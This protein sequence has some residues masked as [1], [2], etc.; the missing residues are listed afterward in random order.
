MAAFAGSSEPVFRN[1][2]L[3]V[4]RAQRSGLVVADGY[5]LNA[6][7]ECRSYAGPE[8]GLFGLNHLGVPY[9]GCGPTQPSWLKLAGVPQI[10]I[11][12]Q[13]IRVLAQDAQDRFTGQPRCWGQ[14]KLR[15]Q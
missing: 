5:A 8:K 3:D 7:S 15:L 13:S 10:E 1:V 2:A 4:V 11:P 6:S 14:G 12:D 9:F